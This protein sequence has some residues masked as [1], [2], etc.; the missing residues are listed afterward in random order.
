MNVQD[1]KISFDELR[2]LVVAIDN[3]MMALYEQKSTTEITDCITWYEFLLENESISEAV[4]IFQK[5]FNFENEKDH[6]KNRVEVRE[7]MKTY[8][9]QNET[10]K[11]DIIIEVT[12]QLF[13]DETKIYSETLGYAGSYLV[14]CWNG[15]TQK[16]ESD[17]TK[18]DKFSKFD[19]KRGIKSEQIL[20]MI[21]LISAFHLI[22][23]NKLISI[24]TFQI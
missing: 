17:P 18:F 22:T 7:K 24:K 15:T 13:K 10:Q 3:L 14:E 23:V 11:L 20:Y 9:S 8:I 12:N 1:L 5:S 4:K 19:L 21:C 2:M 16:N 6:E